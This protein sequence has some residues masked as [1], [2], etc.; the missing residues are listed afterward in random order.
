MIT[1]ERIDPLFYRCSDELEEETSGL[2]VERYERNPD[3]LYIYQYHD[4]GYSRSVV[5]EM[6]KILRLIMNY[7]PNL[8]TKRDIIFAGPVAGHHDVWIDFELERTVEGD[9]EKVMMKRC[10][11]PNE[12]RSIKELCNSMSRKNAE[13]GIEVFL[14]EDFAKAGTIQ[15]TVPQFVEAD[16][17][18]YPTVIQPYLSRE[19]L[20][21]QL[22]AFAFALGGA[23][24]SKAALDP[25]GYIEDGNK[26]FREENIDIFWALTNKEPLSD[27]QKAYF[28]QRILTAT[29]FSIGFP[30]GRRARFEEDLEVL[31]DS[32][33]GPMKGYFRHFEDSSQLAEQVYGRRKEMVF[34]E[35]LENLGYLSDSRSHLINMAHLQR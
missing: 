31:P 15:V 8:V 27:A 6:R 4:R 14:P 10:I 9:F 34:L 1:Q 35:L 18:G 17:Y 22:R 26:L 12:D 3:P 13:Q 23:D 7:R 21:V 25:E 11:G 19:H 33:R 2:I 28:K 30:L 5:S 24:L 20:P 16:A 32:L 29:N